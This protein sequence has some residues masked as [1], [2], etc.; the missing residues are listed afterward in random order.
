MCDLQGLNPGKDPGFSSAVTPLCQP[1][2][3]SDHQMRRK[4]TAL[5]EALKPFPNEQ[6]I[7]TWIRST[8]LPSGA[9]LAINADDIGQILGKI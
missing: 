9:V 6:G 2:K 7:R 5:W 3:T 1:P 4:L 8:L